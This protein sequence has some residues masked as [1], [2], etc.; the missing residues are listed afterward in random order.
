MKGIDIDTW[1]I[2][3]EETS[4]ERKNQLKQNNNTKERKRAYSF[5]YKKI[6]M[7]NKIRFFLKDVG[8]P[9]KGRCL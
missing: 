2:H 9:E 7:Y 1:T 8:G 5:C 6:E 3:D 4:N